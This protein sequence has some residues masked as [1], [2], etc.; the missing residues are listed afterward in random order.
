MKK[1][2]Y[3]LFAISILVLHGCGD[4]EAEQQVQIQQDLDA[5]NYTAVIRELEE[6]ASTE[7]EYMALAAAYMQKAGLGLADL[8][9]VIADATAVENDFD[10]FASFVQSVGERSSTSSLQDLRKSANYFQNVVPNCLSYDLSSSQQDA[11]LYFGLT[12]VMQAANTISY[13]AGDIES[14]GNTLENDAKLQSLACAMEYAF[15]ATLNS[16]ECSVLPRG[17]VVFANGVGY[18]SI[19]VFVDAQEFEHLLSTDGALKH[20][21]ITNGYCTTD[22]FA[23]RVEDKSAQNYDPYTYHVCPLNEAT[24]AD[25]LSTETLMVSAF[26]DGIEAV[27]AVATDDMQGDIDEF[28]CDLLG[29]YYYGGGACSANLSQEITVTQVIEYINKNN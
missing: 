24:A 25:E 21:V 28:K 2:V 19:S 7:E 11:C 1:F 10:A 15:D 18:E 5:G 8:I 27:S 22:D 14:F 6:D 16:L 23:T 3:S 13:M 17:E 26:N 12:Q 29:G 9:R 4:D 20:T